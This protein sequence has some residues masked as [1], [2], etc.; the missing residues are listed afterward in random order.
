MVNTENYSTLPSQP[1]DKR[2][3]P[4]TL[5]RDTS[6]S[7]ATFDIENPVVNTIVLVRGHHREFDILPLSIDTP[8]VGSSRL[9]LKL[10]EASCATRWKGAML[11]FSVRCRRW[12]KPVPSLLP[13]LIKS[14]TKQG[15]NDECEGTRKQ[16]SGRGWLVLR[17]RWLLLDQIFLLL[18]LDDFW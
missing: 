18:F 9:L 1:N 16:R 2:P 4:T 14:R 7:R 12:R 6:L 17:C 8:L 15:W 3:R 13:C 10:E 11:S 5:S